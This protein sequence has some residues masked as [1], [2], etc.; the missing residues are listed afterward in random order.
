MYFLLLSTVWSCRKEMSTENPNGV[1]P[2]TTAGSF[3][4]Q[5]DGVTWT[6]ADSAKGASVLAGQINLI[7]VSTDNQQMSITL[8]DTVPGV[9]TLNQTSVSL[10][11]FASN[12]SSNQYAFTSDQGSDTSQAGGIVTVTEI[13]KT[14]QTISGTFSFKLYR[15]IDGHQKT[16]KNGI[17]SKLPYASSLPPANT[18]DTITASIDGVAWSGESIVAASFSGQ[19]TI[20]GSNLNAS[21]A[22]G[23][24]MPQNVTPGASYTLDYTGFT[25]F[26]LYYPLPTVGLASSSGTLT[27]LEN[28][29][30][31]H[32][33][34]GNFSF[35]AVN[36]QKPTDLTHQLTNGYFSVQY[37]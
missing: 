3:T 1:N 5:I 27:I 12:D 17:F 14:N 24:V 8:N 22:V 25:H 36:P 2:G 10:A 28:N 20:N 11:A 33:I 16:V 34:R 23:L 18:G 35:K 29:S 30:V 13:D 32:R 7:G 26:G 19:I 15:D 37:N 6:A 4:A 31:T 21:Q 9:Y